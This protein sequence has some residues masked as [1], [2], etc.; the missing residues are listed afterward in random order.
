[1][2]PF[3]AAINAGAAS[4]MAAYGSINGVPVT[5]SR[6]VMTELLRDELDFEGMIVTE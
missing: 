4:M 2:P 1:M 3:R 5:A 6:E